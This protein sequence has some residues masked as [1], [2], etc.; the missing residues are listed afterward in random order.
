MQLPLSPSATCEKSDVTSVIMLSLFLKIITNEKSIPPTRLQSGLLK[1]MMCSLT[2][3]NLYL[4]LVAHFLKEY[5][6]PSF[7]QAKPLQMLVHTV[8][9]NGRSW[10]K[11]RRAVTSMYKKLTQAPW[12]REG[13]GLA[14]EHHSAPSKPSE[15]NGVLQINLDE[16]TA[17]VQP[18]I[19]MGEL[20]RSTMRKGRIPTVVASSKSTTVL[21]AFANEACGPSSFR[22]GTFDCAVLSVK[23]VSHG[24]QE[25][26]IRLHDNNA[27]YRHFR[28]FGA[29]SITLF[30]IALIPAGE[31]VKM[32][33]WPVGTVSGATY[34]A[35]PQQRDSLTIDGPAVDDFTDFLDI[36]M[37]GSS[38]GAVIT[39]QFMTAADHICSPLGKSV[40]S[41]HHAES[42]FRDKKQSRKIYV[43]TVPLM[44]YLFR[45]DDCDIHRNSSITEDYDSI[46]QNVF[47]PVESVEKH[48]RGSYWRGS[49]C[50][51]RITR[52]EL[53]S[54]FSRSR[55]GGRA[56]LD[57]T[58]WN[59]RYIRCKQSK[60][61]M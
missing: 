25:S 20:V 55:L 41:M 15:V 28:D 34:R 19:T 1:I 2:Q 5:A 47:L 56:S 7:V 32:T 27:V 38:S 22:Y 37:F 17:W 39:G 61:E 10:Q 42:M 45:Y 58:L 12:D 48:I 31:Y 16:D 4:A 46:G 43:E 54:T 26:T 29:D 14:Q 53:H 44:N 57:S 21:N 9:H 36:V 35:M 8:N 6:N 13:S 40:P 3:C 33:Y 24:G 11:L 51:I 52:A 59:I 50:P 23:V 60:K 30:E 49:S 18:N